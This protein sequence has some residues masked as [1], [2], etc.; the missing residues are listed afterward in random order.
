MSSV[1][2]FL[3]QRVA[4]TTTLSYSGQLYCFI[5]GGGATGTNAASVEAQ[6]NYL[7][8]YPPGFLVAGPTTTNLADP[9]QGGVINQVIRDM[10]KTI[11]A[12]LAADA[13]GAQLGA[14]GFWREIQ[15]LS[16]VTIATATASSNYGVTG[17]A[18]GNRPAYLSGNTGDGGYN[19]YYIPIV[20]GGVAPGNANGVGTLSLTNASLVA[21]DVQ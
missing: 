5:A 1:Q 7:G 11:K 21:G 19:T 17:Q 9:S 13:T 12:R 20:V 16:P 2:R 8:N 14:P 15:V 18:P 10:G 4:G 6:G 3:R